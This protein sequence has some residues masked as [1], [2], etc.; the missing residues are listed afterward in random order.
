MPPKPSI[1]WPAWG[2]RLTASPSG[3]RDDR[4]PLQVASGSALRSEM[5]RRSRPVALLVLLA[6]AAP[7]GIVPAD[8]V[9]V[10]LDDPLLLLAPPSVACLLVHR[11]RGGGVRP[12]R[13]RN[14]GLP[15]GGRLLRGP[16]RVVEAAGLQL[17][18]ELLLGLGGNLDLDVEDQAG[19]LLP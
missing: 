13:G 8:L 5:Q 12:G 10:V 19:E 18:G 14:G 15:E 6:R 1:S 11:L 9:L 17:R 3:R 2:I 7:A 16:T 4:R